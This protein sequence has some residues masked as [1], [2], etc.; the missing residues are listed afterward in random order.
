MQHI[1]GTTLYNCIFFEFN[2]SNN[3]DTLKKHQ[4]FYGIPLIYVTKHE[5][6]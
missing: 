3:D 1:C 4:G 5:Y 6:Y 2:V